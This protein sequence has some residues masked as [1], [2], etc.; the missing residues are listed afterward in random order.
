MTA[1]VNDQIDFV[2]LFLD[3]GVTLDNFLTR[4]RLG[5]LYHE[6]RF[7]PVMP[8]LCFLCII[9]FLMYYDNISHTHPT[10]SHFP[11]HSRCNLKPANEFSVFLLS[12]CTC[13]YCLNFSVQR[14]GTGSSPD[15]LRTRGNVPYLF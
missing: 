12:Y 10:S 9:I 14:E 4:Q 8:R 3:Y 2:K 7:S 5:R 11:L 15:R 1:L 13:M 6:V